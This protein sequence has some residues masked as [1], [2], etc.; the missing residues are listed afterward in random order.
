MWDKEADEACRERN[1]TVYKVVQVTV[2]LILVL[3]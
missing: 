1:F 3:C 2:A